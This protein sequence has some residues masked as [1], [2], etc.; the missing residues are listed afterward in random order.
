M[1]VTSRHH[2]T[3]RLLGDED[4]R[5]LSSWNDTDTGYPTDRRLHDLV[6][7]QVD[8]TPE[9]V[10]VAFEG[11]EVTYA[12]LDARAARVAARLR[13][14]GVGPGVPVGVCVERS[15]EL[16]VALLAVLKAGGAYLPLDPEY[17][18]KR[19]AFMAEDTGVR[20]VLVHGPTTDL[21]PDTGATLV[22]LEDV[23]TDGPAAERGSGGA[24]PGDL[25]YVMYTSGSTGRPK[26]VMV[27]HRSIVNRLLWAPELEELGA[28]DVVL[29]KTPFSFDVSIWEFFWP[30]MTGARLQVARPGGHKDAGYLARLVEDAGVT[31]IHFVPSM[32]DLFLDVEG[33]GRQ[34]RSLRHAVCSGEALPRDLISRFHGKMDPGVTLWNL[35]GPTEAGVE[36]SRW[37]CEPGTPDEAVPIGRPVPNTRLHVVDENL[38]PVPVGES[39]ELIIAGVQVA[40]GYWNRPDLTAE[41]FIPDPVPMEAGGSGGRAYRTGDRARWRSDGVVEFLGRLD[42]QVKLR[43]QRVEPGE[44]EAVLRRSPGVLQAAAVVRNDEAADPRLVAYVVLDDDHAPD[45]DALR[46]DLATG[47]PDYMIP[48][49]FVFLDEMPLSANGKLD[50]SAL[51]APSRRRPQLDRPHTAPRDAVER[52]L[53]EAWAEI[54]GVEPVGIHDP[55]FELG[56][57]SLQ[58]ARFVNRLQDELD[59]VIYVVTV[60]DT[61]TVAGYADFLRRDYPDAVAARFGGPVGASSG[62]EAD[63]AGP[64]RGAQIRASGTGAPRRRI[65]ETDVQRMKEAV[66]RFPFHDPPVAEAGT[67]NESAI[68]VLAPPRSGTTLLRV[69]LAGHPGLFAASELQ[70]LHFERLGQRREAFSGKYEAWLDGAVRTL[71]ELEGRGPDEAKERML[72]LEAADLPVRD[73]YRGIQ[74]RLDGRTLVDKTPSYALDPNALR[75]AERDF[76]RPRYIH[77]VRHPYAVVESFV[78]RHMEQILYLHDHPFDARELGEL[79]WLL[80]HRS[81]GEFL[82]GVPSDRQHRMRFEDLVRKPEATMRGLC[83]GLDIP[84]DPSLLRPYENLEDKMVD[85]V[86]DDSTP[87]GDTRLLERDGIDPT[88]AERWRGV[89]EDD[90]LGDPTWSLA[91]SL[92]YQR[93]AATTSSRRGA[94][95]RSR[96]ERG[97]TRRE[98]TSRPEDEG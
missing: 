54:L 13:E 83:K 72:E 67:R 34:C 6:E 38:D 92:G 84:F 94:M 10:A 77:L 2:R 86:H 71:M 68:F 61:P 58:A 42:D 65:G 22:R 43:G 90:Y 56:G 12:D 74:D 17:P 96:L 69:M 44:V 66:P 51:P 11:T 4:R 85:G 79:V 18:R 48:A 80:S 32:L 63:T 95:R 21:V 62:S 81:V 40:R 26:G 73:F 31:V 64:G 93:P 37:R 47:L 5:S 49:R 25:A 76:D 50:R 8:R 29:Q 3:G 55:F 78:S 59:E 1:T 70:M 23:W 52:F 14:L 20:V 28:D 19:L 41:S 24:G 88:M 30:L 7:A 53:A 97:G 46:K 15:P 98:V 89:L 75:R 87:M 45:G 60:F 82:D 9:R 35:Y 57:S 33:V 91:E 16:V 39:G 27:E 36:V